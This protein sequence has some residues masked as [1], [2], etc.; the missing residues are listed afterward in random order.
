M[1]WLSNAAMISTSVL[2]ERAA[3]IANDAGVSAQRNKGISSVLKALKGARS[4]IREPAGPAGKGLL[5]EAV[6][7]PL[8][9]AAQK[10]AP[11]LMLLKDTLQP[12]I[13]VFLNPA[14]DMQVSPRV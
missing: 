3:A 12:E 2:L 13:R 11:I 1:T 14:R 7:D 9:P 8:S 10:L 5:V 4:A 6:L